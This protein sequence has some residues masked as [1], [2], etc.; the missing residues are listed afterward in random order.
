MAQAANKMSF[1][2]W[3][4]LEISALAFFYSPASRFPNTDKQVGSDWIIETSAMKKKSPKKLRP[5]LRT[6]VK[7][8]WLDV[9]LL[10]IILILVLTSVIPTALTRI[11]GFFF[12]PF[13]T[14]KKKCYL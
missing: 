10:C 12:F 8:C 2:I 5:R 9:Y 6:D 4:G 13:G 1:C 3:K 7:H 11:E 14:E